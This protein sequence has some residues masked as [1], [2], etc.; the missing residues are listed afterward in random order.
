MRVRRQGWCRERVKERKEVAGVVG[1]ETRTKGLGTFEWPPSL[2]MFTGLL[3]VKWV[4]NAVTSMQTASKH[5][6]LIHCIVLEPFHAAAFVMVQS[7][8]SNQVMK[9]AHVDCV[10][11]GSDRDTHTERERERGRHGSRLGNSFFTGIILMAA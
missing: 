2:K 1:K 6:S 4:T 3:R 11:R 7:A 5:N 9:L 10:P 8:G